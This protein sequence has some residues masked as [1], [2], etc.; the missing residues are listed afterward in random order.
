[1]YIVDVEL[2]IASSVREKIDLRVKSIH[3]KYFGVLAV[4]KINSAMK[5]RKWI[6]HR[7]YDS[8]SAALLDNFSSAFPAL[9]LRIGNSCMPSLIINVNLL[10]EQSMPFV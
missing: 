3:R 8:S 9:E 10:Y 6:M 5:T 1:M 7:N 4:D 2:T